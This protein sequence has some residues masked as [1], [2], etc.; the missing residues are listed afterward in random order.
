MVAKSTV[1]WF[2][3][4]I[5]VLLIA[6]YIQNVTS[7][8]GKDSLPNSRFSSEISRTHRRNNT[9]GTIEVRAKIFNCIT[10]L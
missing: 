3:R 2:D 10:S 4:R 1:L 7:F 9:R 6:F 8:W 5:L